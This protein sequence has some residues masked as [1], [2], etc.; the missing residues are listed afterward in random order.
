MNR[1]DMLNGNTMKKMQRTRD[2][3]NQG[4][5]GVHELLCQKEWSGRPLGL[6][7]IIQD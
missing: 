3:K 1:Y 7:D 2:R 5:E 4:M 6:S